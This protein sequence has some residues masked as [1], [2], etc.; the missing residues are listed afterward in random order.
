MSRFF[1]CAI[2]VAAVLS[3]VRPAAPQETLDKLAYLT[4]SAPVHPVTH[5]PV[6]LNT[7][8][9]WVAMM[10]ALTVVNYGFPIAQL[11]SLPG[12]SVPAVRMGVR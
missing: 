3:V 4:F 2:V 9:L 10:V 1:A 12:T 6:A 11:A 5:V 7:F 8:G